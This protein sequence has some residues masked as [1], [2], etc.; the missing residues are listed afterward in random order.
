MVVLL[1]KPRK[2]STAIAG[3]G[4]RLYG[5]GY[6]R[7]EPARLARRTSHVAREDNPRVQ[8]DQ[9]SE[10]TSRMGTA[11]PDV[12][13]QLFHPARLVRTPPA[14]PAGE[15]THSTGGVDVRLCGIR[16]VRI[17]PRRGS[18]YPSLNLVCSTSGWGQAGRQAL[19]STPATR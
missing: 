2:H 5:A 1:R 17:E 7:R 14:R 12:S 10:I 3:M 15:A 8:R 16:A 19:R 13:A 6:L 4:K 11:L 9:S 18:A